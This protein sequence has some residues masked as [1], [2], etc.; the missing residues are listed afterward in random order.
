MPS[1]PP[2]YSPE[3]PNTVGSPHAIRPSP[4]IDQIAFVSSPL[5][6]EPPISSMPSTTTAR[7]SP[8]APRSPAFPP[9]PGQLSRNRE[10]SASG[11]RFLNTI[12]SL[13]GRGKQ[14][15]GN[16]FHASQSVHYPS[17]SEVPRAP[18][19]RRAASTGHMFPATSSSSSPHRPVPTND[20]GRSSPEGASWRPG[21]PLPGP[22]PGPPPP[23]ARSQSLNRF[24]AT[25]SRSNSVTSEQESSTPPPQRRAA[26]QPSTLGPV[27]PT[28]ADWNDNDDLETA[29]RSIEQA[30][31]SHI[32]SYQP[33]R[34]NTGAI[35]DSTTQR[36]SR[37]DASTDGL[38][39]RR[40]KSRA[41]REG[42]SS[43][44]MSPISDDSRPSDFV[45]STSSGSISQRREHM[46]KI[47]GYASVAA[48]P[49]DP[50]NVQSKSLTATRTKTA[51][52]PE[53]TSILTP[54]Y[55]PAVGSQGG[56]GSQRRVLAGPSS[57]PSE[58]PISL[59]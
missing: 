28:P 50:S 38:R 47:S 26:A 30:H 31:G 45:A 32:S 41:A 29:I 48:V 43:N 52:V 4:A 6:A 33:L 14:P 23:G 15:A 18:A 37:R 56:D 42:S 2:P 8:R 20:S 27:P 22:P 36:P 3:T 13:T 49:I 16:E 25:S 34:I 39:E 5:A 12:H 44:V 19:A 54:P 24:P 57:A 9:P 1:P 55:T 59:V 11:Q 46:R 40:S 21:M 35:H 53:T 51:P 7:H 10:R 58:R 17:G